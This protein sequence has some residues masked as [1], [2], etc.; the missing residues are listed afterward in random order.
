MIT[1]TVLVLF[2]LLPLEVVQYREK[3]T[4]CILSFVLNGFIFLF[5]MFYTRRKQSISMGIV[6]WIF[7]FFFM[8]FAP[9]IQ[10]LKSKFPWRGSFTE[11]EIL[12][13]NFVV[14]LFNISFL[15]GRIAAKKIRIKGF[16]GFKV[17]EFICSDFSF[18]R[19]ARAIMTLLA[20]L[21]TGYSFAKTGLLGIVVARVQ[22]TQVF[23]SGNNSAVEMI[24][25]S[26]IPAFMAYVV[27][28][29]AQNV[30]AK[31]EKPW[32]FLLLV[33]CILVCFF[34]TSLPRYKTITIYGTVFLVMFPSLKK[35][36]K[37]FWIFVL[38]LFFAFPIMN[39]FR[40]MLSMEGLREVFDDGV[41]SVYTDADYDAYRML[42]SAISYARN[43]GA[44][45][46]FP[47]LGA[48][49][50]FVPRSVWPTKPG[51]SGAMLIRAELGADTV[52]NVSC[53]FIGEGYLNF[54][55]VG[56]LLFGLFMGIWI[57]RLDRYYW[58]CHKDKDYVVFSPYLFIVFM[59][60][61]MLRGD[62]LSSFAYLCGF[63]VTGYL[64]RFASKHI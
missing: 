34:P 18:S 3:S 60:F 10:Y 50:F 33:L 22:A 40:H 32:R 42:A 29:A 52:S 39:G 4:L 28:E 63:I 12:M 25:E 46:G 6:Y 20:C 54:G 31:R 62:L 56:M 30:S 49:L 41:L 17:S 19:K 7:M 36:T 1:M 27:A 5:G 26:V 23:Y 24:V 14:L 59:L 11:D 2:V 38:A 16:R 35:G 47:L 57:Y 43:Y 45:W 48:L 8:Y 13:T 61:F 44:E 37:F 53:P 58:H 15:L 64:L 21:V 9:L 55:L 51:G